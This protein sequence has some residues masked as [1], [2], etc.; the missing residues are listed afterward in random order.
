MKQSLNFKTFS[1]AIRQKR[2][3]DK[4]IGVRE[5]SK[6]IGISFSTLSRCENER[7]PELIAYANICKWLGVS[8]DTFIVK[9]KKSSFK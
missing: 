2:I 4:N 7:M 5:A 3:I 9:A 1:K 6:E 8:L